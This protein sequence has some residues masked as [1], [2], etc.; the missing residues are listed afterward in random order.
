MIIG[1]G[2]DLIDIRES[3]KRWSVMASASPVASLPR[4][5]G[6]SPIA[7]RSVPRP[8]YANA[9][10]PRRPVPRRSVPGLSQGV[11]WREHGR[12]Q[13]AQRETD[14]AADQWGGGAAGLDGARRQVG[15]DPSD[16]HRRLPA[17]AGFCDHRSSRFIRTTSRRNRTK[18]CRLPGAWQV[19]K[20]RPSPYLTA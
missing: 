2:S 9:S 13:P 3:R 12:G 14:H 19:A 4:S 11:F 8:S 18:E 20:T 5:S 15:C 10:R 16:D 1:I 7:A 17:R 6:R